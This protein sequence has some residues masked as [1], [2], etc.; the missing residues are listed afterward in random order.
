MYNQRRPDE[1]PDQVA[2]GWMRQNEVVWSQWKPIDLK[3]K[4]ELYIG[5][6]F[7]LTGP[8]YSDKGMVPGKPPAA[9]CPPSIVEL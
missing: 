2:C 6:I 5:G 1:T 9:T 4:T 7:P 8:Y 3:A